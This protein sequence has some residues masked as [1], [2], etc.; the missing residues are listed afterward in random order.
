MVVTRKVRKERPETIWCR[1]LSHPLPWLG[2]RLAGR[3]GA[4]LAGCVSMTIGVAL[5]LTLCGAIVGL[6]LL[7]LGLLLV[8]RGLF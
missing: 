1:L 7:A 8:I 6:P 5:T 4:I 3:A 2:V